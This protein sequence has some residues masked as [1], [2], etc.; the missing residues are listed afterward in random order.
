M[1]KALGPIIHG[2]ETAHF[3]LLLSDWRDG[4][5]DKDRM[6]DTC[7]FIFQGAAAIK[8]RPF[9]RVG[10][11]YRFHHV[12]RTALGRD[13]NRPFHV[14]RCQ[15]SPQ[16]LDI[17]QVVP[18]KYQPEWRWSVPR[19]CTGQCE[20][21]S[22]TSAVLREHGTLA[23]MLVS[24]EGTIEAYGKTPG[25]Y[26]LK[27][28]L[29]LPKVKLKLV[30]AAPIHDLGMGLRPS[31]KVR[32]MNAHPIYVSERLRVSSHSAMATVDFLYSNSC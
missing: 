28:S 10:R 16:P 9:L 25:W 22:D 15:G 30:L 12:V 26:K 1:V 5:D 2:K 32:L 4:I 19:S 17:S 11:A 23:S 21:N 31:A 29:Q 27:S 3:L 7:T 14:F 20:G 18:W 6:E 13:V 24:Y 8:W